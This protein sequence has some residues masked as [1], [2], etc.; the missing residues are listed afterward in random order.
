MTHLR[1]FERSVVG[2]A[3]RSQGTRQQ[4]HHLRLGA[5]HR[6]ASTKAFLFDTKRG[7]GQGRWWRYQEVWPGAAPQ[8]LSRYQRSSS[9]QMDE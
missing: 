6:F 3:R 2:C 4:Q 8:A 5:S 7:V 1:G 9:V